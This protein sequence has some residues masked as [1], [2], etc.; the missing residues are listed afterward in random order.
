MSC[1]YMMILQCLHSISVIVI[2]IK[3]KQVNQHNT[4]ISLIKYIHIV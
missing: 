3:C 2:A 1:C 4:H